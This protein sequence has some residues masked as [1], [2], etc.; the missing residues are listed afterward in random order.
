METPSTTNHNEQVIHTGE[1]LFNIDIAGFSSLSKLLCVTALCLRFIAKLRQ[2]KCEA[3]CITSE[4][5]F[6]AEEMWV[7]LV[8]KQSYQNVFEAISETKPRTLQQQLGLYVDHTNCHLCVP[9]PV[10]L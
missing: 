8:Q 10:F 2:R 5:I 4:E 3:G 7:R 6:V 9:I 1:K